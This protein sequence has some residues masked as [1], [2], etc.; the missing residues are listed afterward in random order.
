MRIKIY[1]PDDSDLNSFI[2]NLHGFLKRQ[3]GNYYFA[4][5]GMYGFELLFN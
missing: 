3:Y 2:H 4:G 1:F 5:H